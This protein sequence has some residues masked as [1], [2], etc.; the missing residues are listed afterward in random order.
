[1][2]SIPSPTNSGITL[3]YFG[4]EIRGSYVAGK[5]LRKVCSVVKIRVIADL[6]LDIRRVYVIRKLSITTTWRRPP[7]VRMAGVADKLCA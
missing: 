3:Y 4:V 7:V 6:L 5:V 2:T 1:M